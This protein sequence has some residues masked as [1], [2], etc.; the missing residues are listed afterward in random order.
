MNEIRDHKYDDFKVEIKTKDS[1]ILKDV[2][3]KTPGKDNFLINN[4]NLS[5]ET[6]KALI[7]WKQ[8]KRIR[9][10]REAALS[11]A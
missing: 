2:S 9:D 8:F 5:I 1:I 10:D 6:E 7:T 3:I 11:A 4:L